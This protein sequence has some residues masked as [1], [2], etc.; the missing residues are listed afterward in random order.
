MY[1]TSSLFMLPRQLSLPAKHM[2]GKTDSAGCSKVRHI[3][4]GV[5]P[6]Q[7]ERGIKA[8]CN[9]H[10]HTDVCVHFNNAHTHM[11]RR[12]IIKPAKQG[13]THYSLSFFCFSSM[14]LFLTQTLTHT[15][16]FRVS[17]EWINQSFHALSS[18]WPCSTVFL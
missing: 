5:H 6:G 15:H 11:L 4:A 10:K 9:T 7:R 12:S 18:G 13:R 17:P 3:Q 16:I 1:S 14:S 2:Y 8:G